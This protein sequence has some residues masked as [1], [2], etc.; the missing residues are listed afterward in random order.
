MEGAQKTVKSYQKSRIRSKQR[1]D[2]HRREPTL[3]V[4]GKQ[5]PGYA[6]PMAVVGRN[7]GFL[8]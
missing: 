7:E 1:M 3:T 8:Q 4:G 6:G 5:K 2:L